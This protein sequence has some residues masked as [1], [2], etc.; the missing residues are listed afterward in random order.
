MEERWE[1]TSIKGRNIPIPYA[2]LTVDVEDSRKVDLTVPYGSLLVFFGSMLHASYVNRQ[3]LPRLSV[4]T[5]ITPLLLPN[6]LRKTK[7]GY[8]TKLHATPVTERL[9]R[10]YPNPETDYL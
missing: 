10:C 7:P 8:F 6:V 4:D 3:P 2:P 9:L 1:P 5:R